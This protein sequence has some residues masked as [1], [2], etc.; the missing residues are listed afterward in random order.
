MSDDE[1]GDDGKGQISKEELERAVNE[2]VGDK[3]KWNKL[4]KR[5]EAYAHGII[6]CMI[7]NRIEPFTERGVNPADLLKVLDEQYGIVTNAKG[8]ERLI[9]KAVDSINYNEGQEV[10]GVEVHNKIEM[11]D[12]TH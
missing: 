5:S 4:I 8:L 9:C 3:T 1:K 10:L 11:P 12:T 6:H 2:I 7:V